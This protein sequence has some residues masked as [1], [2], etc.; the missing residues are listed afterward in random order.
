MFKQLETKFSD[1]EAR[2]SLSSE[3][4]PAFRTVVKAL[5]TNNGKILIGK[6]EETG[7]PISGQWHILGGQLEKGE[8][9]EEAVK[10]EVKEETGLEVKIHQIIDVKTFAWDEEEKDSIQGL[11]HVESDTRDAEALDDLEEVKWVSPE[12]L[13]DELGEIEASRIRERYRQ[14]KF[15]EKMKKAPI[16]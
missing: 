4:K 6:K 8:E 3:E 11:Y 9:F 10:R 15:L 12:N 13:L 16:F 2:K 14:E 1:K 7:H 5:I